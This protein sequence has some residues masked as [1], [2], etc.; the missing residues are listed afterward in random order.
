MCCHFSR[1]NLHIRLRLVVNYKGL[2]I[3]AVRDVFEKSLGLR[4]RK[5]NPNTDYHCLKTFA[6]YFTK[7]IPIPAV[8]LNTLV[9]SR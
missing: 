3:G 6:S 8:R 4:L 9:C 2:S 7:D 1:E 5:I